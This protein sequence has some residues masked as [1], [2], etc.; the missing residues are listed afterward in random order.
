MSKLVNVFNYYD[1]NKEK[2]AHS[3]WFILLCSVGP[4]IGWYFNSNYISYLSL[5]VTTILILILS[6]DVRLLLVPLPFA[7][8]C[9]R[10]LFYFDNVPYELI[11]FVVVYVLAIVIMMVKHF[12]KNKMI[13]FKTNLISKSLL[14]LAIIAFLSAVVRHIFYNEPA[15]FDT[16]NGIV[17]YPE[18][19]NIMYGYLGGL[20]LFGLFFLSSIITTFKIDGYDH[21]FE[22]SMYS[23]GLFIFIQFGISGIQNNFDMTSIF[24]GAN[25]IGWCDK[26]TFAIAAQITL[27]FIAYIFS[28]N[29]KRID[30]FLLLSL[31]SLIILGSNSRSAQ[32]TIMITLFFVLYIL[33]KPTKK[34]WRNYFIIVGAA[35]ASFILAYFFIP[36][37]QESINRLFN[38]IFNGNSFSE[39]ITG[40]DVF[41][42][43]IVDYTYKTPSHILFGGSTS[44]LFELYKAFYPASQ[45]L[46]V[47]L[48]HNTFMTALAL[49]GTLG[50]IAITYH[51]FEAFGSTLKRLGDRKIV[52]FTLLLFGFI[53]G[54]GDN[55]FF[56][57]VFMIPYIFILS[58]YEKK[59][60]ELL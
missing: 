1:N 19:Y 45:E 56:N 3:L 13:H 30:A 53:H 57:V 11:A 49:G 9:F 47:W 55:T 44:Y 6:Y 24:Y 59:F 58:S 46:G 12:K 35:A 2:I 8:T 23:F 39:I 32:L 14:I 48:C 42:K 16:A 5:S 60:N 27:P 54:L 17:S 26:N 22:N 31:L 29:Y 36:S 15:S 10:E 33:V 40:R 20:L 18:S 7:M 38:S 52:V 21:M 28:K 50:L 25:G 37:L 4:L 41:W 43:W 34:V 51:L